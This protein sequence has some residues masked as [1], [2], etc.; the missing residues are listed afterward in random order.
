[1]I[2]GWQLVACTGT[3]VIELDCWQMRHGM[4]AILNGVPHCLHTPAISRSASAI[5][6]QIAHIGG[7]VF[8][9]ALA[10]CANRVNAS[11]R[12]QWDTCG[13]YACFWCR[14]VGR[15]AGGRPKVADVVGHAVQSVGAGGVL[16]PD[17]CRGIYLESDF[18]DAIPV[19]TAG[20]AGEAARSDALRQVIV[21]PSVCGL[22][23]ATL[24]EHS[25]F[26]HP[27]QV[28]HVATD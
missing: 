27:P 6:R 25:F 5:N 11:G 15:V 17:L 4:H 21:S 14:S 28:A 19:L 16:L 10:T 24:T 12:F 13:T 2:L 3:V 23:K 8:L 1:M 18:R 20:L 7:V 26:T 9:R 22:N